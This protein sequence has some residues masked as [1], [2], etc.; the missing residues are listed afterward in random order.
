MGTGT[1]P[2]IK[3]L[4]RDADHRGWEWVELYLYSP[5]RPLVAC[6]RVSFIFTFTGLVIERGCCDRKPRRLSQDF[7]L[8]K[9]H[10]MKITT[11][12]L[13]ELSFLLSSGRNLLAH[14]AYAT[15]PDD[16]LMDLQI[17][18][19]Q[20]GTTVHTT[21]Q[22]VGNFCGNVCVTSC[23]LYGESCWNMYHKSRFVL[24]QL[25]LMYM[26]LR[27]KTVAQTRCT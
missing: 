9:S 12:W 4:G 17:C 10:L 25:L 21:F 16:Q 20:L 7:A 11:Q 27:R 26:N 24:Y 19:H 8:L 3:L 2:G 1:F 13:R 6:Y 22:R 23:M 15:G 18:S 14:R 5:S